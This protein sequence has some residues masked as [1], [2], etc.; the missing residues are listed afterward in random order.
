MSDPKTNPTQLCPTCGTRVSVE[1]TRCLVCGT[2]LGTPSKPAQPAKS[3][4]GSRMPEVTLS[5]PVAI[6]LLAT[7][8]AIGA[9]LVYLA[10][11]SQ[12][13]VII[14][15]T[16]TPTI[17]VTLTPTL[18]PT[19]LPPT[20]TP[21]PEP[22][23]TPITYNVKLGDNC[24]SIAAFFQV[25]VQSI[26]TLN[27]LPAACD[28]LYENQPLLIPQPT[29]TPT[30]LPTATLSAAQQTEAACEKI[31]YEVK[32][33]D[34]LGSIAA[35]Y[36]VSMSAIREYNGLTGDTVFLGQTIT[37]P[38]CKRNAPPGPTPTAS[39]PP[40]YAA[41]NL[42]LPADGAPFTLANDTVTLQWASVGTLAENEAYQVTVEDITL[43]DGTKLVDYV[44]D[45]KFIIPSTIRPTEVL[46]HV[47]RW[48]I[49]VV[50][51]SGTDNSG[52]PIWATAGAISIP[53]VFTWSGMSISTTTTP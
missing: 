39:P 16:E 48:T 14:P 28:T 9:I 51:Q 18:T 50:R 20:L 35:N 21:T 23:P 36:D 6:L 8:L 26:V 46:P 1:A 34:T 49:S 12:P 22:S 24:L 2:E 38:L 43:G 25:S 19:E 11:R 53:R 52:N 41:P 10:L 7:F 15:A 30:P 5:I 47:Y 32:S 45:T 17:T 40:P 3:V 4:Q 31:T 42:L 44:T 37:I 29:A 27:N 33:N 13:E